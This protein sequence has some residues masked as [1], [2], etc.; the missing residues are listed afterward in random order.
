MVWVGSEEVGHFHRGQEDSGVKP[1]AEHTCHPQ[2]ALL[3]FFFFFFFLF[4]AHVWPME[5]PRLGVELELYPLA[6]AT[7]IAMWDPSSICD[8][9]HS[10]W[11][12]RILTPLSGARD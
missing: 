10:S 6:Y 8:L 2:H 5:V 9:H 11:Q 3:L 4:R 1:S 7:A 12:G